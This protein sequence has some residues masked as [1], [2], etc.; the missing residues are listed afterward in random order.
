MKATT[1]SEGTSNSEKVQKMKIERLSMNMPGHRSVSVV[2][3]CDR[4]FE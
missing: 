4:R 3:L 2:G 1:H